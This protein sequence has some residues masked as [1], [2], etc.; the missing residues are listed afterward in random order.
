M[1]NAFE[2]V[3]SQSRQ[4]RKA[5]RGHV[6]KNFEVTLEIPRDHAM[7]TTTV[8]ARN[9]AGAESKAIIGYLNTLR[10]WFTFRKYELVSVREV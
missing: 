9:A 4:A 1:Y 10:G 2:L 3:Y 7:F 8:T 6:M 5:T